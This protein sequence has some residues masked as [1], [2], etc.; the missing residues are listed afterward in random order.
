MT[1]GGYEI[2]AG[3]IIN[4]G[5]FEGEREWVPYYYGLWNEG[6][7]DWE[8]ETAAMFYLGDT[9]FDNWLEMRGSIS[10]VIEE[11]DQGFVRGRLVHLTEEEEEEISPNRSFPIE[12]KKEER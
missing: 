9:D 11:D 2:V 4:P 5:K 12:A 6:L 3:R 1:E 10:V 7:A 8:D